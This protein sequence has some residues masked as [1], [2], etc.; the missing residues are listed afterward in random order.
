MLPHDQQR[1]AA[2]RLHRVPHRARRAL[3]R[4]QHAVPDAAHAEDRPPRATR[5]ATRRSSTTTTIWL[6]SMRPKSIESGA[7]Q[8]ARNSSPTCTMISETELRIPP[9]ATAER[10]S[11]PFFWRKRTCIAVSAATGTARLEN[12]IADCSSML[13]HTGRRIGHVAE[14]RDAERDVGARC[15]ARTPARRTTSSAFLHRVP[16]HLRV[17]DPA[18]EHADRHQRADRHQQAAGLDPVEPAE[19]R[20]FGARGRGADV[21]GARRGGRRAG[22]ARRARRGSS[23]RARRAGAPGARRPTV[24]LPMTAHRGGDRCVAAPTIA[25]VAARSCATSPAVWRKPRAARREVEP[26]DAHRPGRVGAVDEHVAGVELAVRDARRVERAQLGPHVVEQLG[27]SPRRRR[28]RTARCPRPPR[29][30]A[31]RAVRSSP[32]TT[33]RGASTPASRAEQHRGTPRTPPAR[34]GWGAGSA[35]RRGTTT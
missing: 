19:L 8:M 1:E 34:A 14:E 23:P 28:A 20:R 25:V 30:R 26:D 10:R 32:A 13:G 35:A 18:E 24:S 16:E 3:D 9:A 5:R 31:A 22:R 11:R 27:R 12:D 2:R 15:R 4:W 21:R 6:V 29:P 17:A 33:T 7:S